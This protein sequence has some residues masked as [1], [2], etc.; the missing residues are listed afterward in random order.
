[1]QFSVKISFDSN[2]TTSTFLDLFDYSKA[3]SIIAEESL[4]PS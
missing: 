2:S 3:Y 1:M 4:A